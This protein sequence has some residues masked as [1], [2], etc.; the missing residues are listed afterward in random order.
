MPPAV[1]ELPPN[2]AVHLVESPGFATRAAE[3]YAEHLTPADI[4]A[5]IR[6]KWNV[7][8]PTSIVTFHRLRDVFVVGEGL[9]FDRGCNLYAASLTQNSAAQIDAAREAL[10][11]AMLTSAIPSHLGTT[12]L[13]GKAGM[14]NYG[15][16]LIEMLPLAWLA[17]EF[18]LRDSWKI[19]IPHVYE[20]MANVIADSLRLIRLPEQYW[21]M[22]KG[23]PRHFEEL[24]LITGLTAHGQFYS[25]LV[26]DCMDELSGSVAS[27][28]TPQ[29]WLTRAGDRRA[30]HNEEALN[31]VLANAGWTIIDPGKISLVE[32]IK[33]VRG[34][35]HLAG[36]NG[37]GLTNLVFLTAPAT[38]TSFM[39]AQMFDVFFW[40]LAGHRNI[41][42]REH[43]C[44]HEPNTSGTIW[45]MPLQI[46][47]DE[48]LEGLRLDR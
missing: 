5:T 26:H 42:Y 29:V 24:V 41:R 8:H 4:N 15:H 21:I 12:L 43:R 47:A 13:C 16:W 20:W 28:E 19:L 14:N 22:S 17:R 38:V 32:Q 46:T 9:V 3:V 1:I 39:P 18:I 31:S 33:S 37:A 10:N 7:S 36:V 44:P 27:G 35:R 30:I 48:V 2:S 25:P 23:Q 45:D 34:A 40:Q 6:S 11:A